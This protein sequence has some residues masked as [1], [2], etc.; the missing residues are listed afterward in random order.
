MKQ[1]G[2]QN[3]LEAVPIFETRA[4]NLLVPSPVYCLTAGAEILNRKYI[5]RLRVAIT[6]PAIAD[7]LFLILSQQS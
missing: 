3:G 2:G 5:G 7:Q 4:R 6:D 1:D